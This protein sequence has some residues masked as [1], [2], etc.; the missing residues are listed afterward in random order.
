MKKLF[1]TATLLILALLPVLGQDSKIL[2][3]FDYKDFYKKDS[4]A[5]WLYV[6]DVIAWITSDV[7][8]TESEEELQQLGTEWFC[9]E[10]EDGNWHAIYG[11]YENNKMNAVFH[12]LVDYE[13]K[14][15]RVFEDIDTAFLNPHARA[16]ITANSEIASIKESVPIRFNQYIKQ[17]DDKTFSVFIFPALQTNGWAV[18]GGEFVY[19]IDSTGTTILEDNS[20]YQ[21]KFA[22]YDTNNGRN[23]RI[24]L[25]YT[26]LENP[27][28]GN[29]FFM[30]YY[31][32]YFYS[33]IIE[34]KNYIHIVLQ[35]QDRSYN[36]MH[37][38][39]EPETK[40]LQ[41]N[42]ENNTEYK[43][44]KQKVAH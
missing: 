21:G 38:E 19:T 1:I 13:D 2:S 10:T 20:Y 24:R 44:I 12:Y 26:E 43:K 17:N 22:Y 16:L 36:W 3:G 41:N 15:T 31:R 30:W 18:Y 7:G 39:R 33:I 11:K 42:K 5:R 34:N 35:H 6:Y 23:M 27:T 28:L 14:I 25:D 40:R 9:F 8:V 32:R 37:V 29:V 4:I